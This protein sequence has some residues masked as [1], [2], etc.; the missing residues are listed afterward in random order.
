MSASN[1]MITKGMAKQQ[2]AS[3]PGKVVITPTKVVKLSALSPRGVTTGASKDEIDGMI[4]VLT[5]MTAEYGL[6]P[7]LGL[8][9]AFLTS[10][11]DLPPWTTS[12]VPMNDRDKAKALMGALK[13]IGMDA[14]LEKAWA[15]RA[16]FSPPKRV[17]PPNLGSAG[18]AKPGE[19]PRGTSHRM[20]TAPVM[21]DDGTES[22]EGRDLRSELD[23]TKASPKK[24]TPKQSKSVSGQKRGSEGRK[25][26]PSKPKKHKK[27]R[28]AEGD[29]TDD[30][31]EEDSDSSG[32]EEDEDG[33]EGHASVEEIVG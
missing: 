33:P 2:P 7:L 14:F 4:G 26:E 20:T 31:A 15:I 1:R 10:F 17:H 5:A 21:S 25:G 18:K 30:E 13:S 24:G 3:L 28:G 32:T 19:S 16:I 11:Y 6:P 29:D 12:S 23:R 22:H 8:E 27:R 9:Y